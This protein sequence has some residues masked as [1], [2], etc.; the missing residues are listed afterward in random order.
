[1]W[2][3][4]QWAPAG[5]LGRRAREAELQVDTSGRFVAVFRSAII[6][7]P[8]GPE[9]A[10][11]SAAVW[12]PG[13]ADWDPVHEFVDPETIATGTLAWR[14]S[15]AAKGPLHV[16]MSHR[17]ELELRTRL[18]A[19]LLGPNTSN[20]ADAGMIDG[21]VS[22]G[23]ARAHQLTTAD[24]GS[25]L[26]VWTHQVEESSEI[27]AN[28]FDPTTR[29]WRTGFSWRLSTTGVRAEHPQVAATAEGRAVAVW[30]HSS[31]AAP[32]LYFSSYEPAI[33]EWSTPSKLA[34]DHSSEDVRLVAAGNGSILAV[35]HEKAEGSDTG[36]IYAARHAPAAR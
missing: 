30:T 22:T 33:N 11:T 15:V 3:A 18:H 1:M 29:S 26:V 23:H 35:W 17:D 4:D 14:A 8:S 34:D 27:R 28:R 32:G 31:G 24:D 25:A 36:T 16:V 20:W 5:K 2:S 12:N 9:P 7:G 13:K 21:G 6:L 19:H 10:T